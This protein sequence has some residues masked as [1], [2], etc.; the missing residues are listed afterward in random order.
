MTG[1]LTAKVNTTGHKLSSND[2]KYALFQSQDGVSNKARTRISMC[3]HVHA[4]LYMC[5][6]NLSLL[7]ASLLKTIEVN[8]SLRFKIS[9]F[10]SSLSVARYRHHYFSAST[11]ILFVMPETTTAQRLNTI[12]IHINH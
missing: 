10:S 5:F 9:H 3:T 7:F 1:L 4:P 2:R 8:E 12:Y 11:V 6:R